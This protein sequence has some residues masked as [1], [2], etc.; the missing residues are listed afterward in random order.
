MA[1]VADTVLGAQQAIGHFDS[2]WDVAFL[3]QSDATQGRPM[4]M[5]ASQDEHLIL[6][7]LDS[8]Q[9]LRRFD[10]GTGM[11]EPGR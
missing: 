1:G 7:D 11:L 4:A 2:V 10:A 3:P 9:L 5:S 8:G 6:W